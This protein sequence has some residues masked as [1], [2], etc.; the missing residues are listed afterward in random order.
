M[1]N[2][3][4]EKARDCSLDVS[5]FGIFKDALKADVRLDPLVCPIL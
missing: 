4:A 1:Q 3:Q 2:N 5:S